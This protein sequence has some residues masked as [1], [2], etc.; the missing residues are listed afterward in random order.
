MPATPV[1]V[2]GTLCGEPLA[3]EAMLTLALVA[4]AAVGV[5][6]TDSVQL[7][8]AGRLEPQSF[9]TANP[10][11][12]AMLESASGAEPLLLRVTVRAPEATP[13]D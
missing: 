10:A 2:R 3:F 13:I 9:E 4:P 11:L 5:K 1:P 12:A 8:A 6:T 7:A